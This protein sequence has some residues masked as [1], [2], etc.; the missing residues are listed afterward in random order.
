MTFMSCYLS[1]NEGIPTYQEKLNTLKDTITELHSSLVITGNLNVRARKWGMPH[2]DSRGK[3][4]S[5]SVHQN[6]SVLE[7]GRAKPVDNLEHKRGF[8]QA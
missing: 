7:K 6:C 3:R 5:V 2:T 1:L 8:R 4:R